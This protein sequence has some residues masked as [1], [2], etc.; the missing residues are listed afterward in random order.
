[1]QGTGGT[2]CNF[3]PAMTTDGYVTFEAA[4]CPGSHIGVLPSGQITAP[5]QTNKTTDASHFRVVYLVR[6][7]LSA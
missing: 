3:V 7:M 6:D 1:M 4:G 2:E 5:A